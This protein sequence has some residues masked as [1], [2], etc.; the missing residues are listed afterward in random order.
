MSKDDIKGMPDPHVYPKWYRDAMQG[1]TRVRFSDELNISQEL[2]NRTV[3]GIIEHELEHVLRRGKSDID[4]RVAEKHGMQCI[5]VPM[6]SKD[7]EPSREFPRRN[8]SVYLDT[9]I[10]AEAWLELDDA[11]KELREHPT[12]AWDFIDGEMKE[13]PSTEDE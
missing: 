9:G 10:S 5:D 8:F 11:M 6:L 3:D 7:R 12:K 1:K 2:Y 13:V 4:H